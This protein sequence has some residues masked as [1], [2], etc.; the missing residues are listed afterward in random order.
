M[1]T[2]HL[3]NEL[4]GI[5]EMI[6]RVPITLQTKSA[7]QTRSIASGESKKTCGFCLASSANASIFARRAAKLLGETKDA[8]LKAG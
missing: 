6:L 5:R 8:T 2:A 1:D 4:A 7:F 3:L